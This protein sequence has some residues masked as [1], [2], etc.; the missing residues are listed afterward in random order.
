MLA[1]FLVKV[2]LELVN[3]WSLHAEFIIIII[4]VKICFLLHVFVF[5]PIYN[6]YSYL[7]PV[8]IHWM[9]DEQLKYILI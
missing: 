3:E 7:L 8:G 2:N 4:V 1:L 9:L 6:T 5:V